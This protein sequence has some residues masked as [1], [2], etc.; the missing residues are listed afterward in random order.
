MRQFIVK[1]PEMGRPLNTVPAYCYKDKDRGRI[2]WRGQTRDLPGK[3]KSAESWAAYHELCSIVE[4]TGELPKK[5][6]DPKSESECRTMAHLGRLYLE[7]MREKFGEGS[8]EPVCRGYAIRACNKL[9][10]SLPIEQFLPPQLKAVRDS[11][12]KEGCVR[13]TVNKRARQLVKLIQWS[14]E[15]GYSHP[16]QWSRLKAVDPIGAGQFGAID[17]PKIGPV[18]D[19][20]FERTLKLVKPKAA[21]ALQVLAITGMRTGE[22]L[23]MRPCEVDKSGRHWLYLIEEHKTSKKTGAGI[24]VIPEPAVEI[25]CA[26]MPRDYTQRWFPH[27]A[28]WLRLAV[29]RAC[30]NAGIPRWHPHQLRHRF[31]TNAAKVLDKQE[32]QA[33]LRHHDPRMTD[34]YTAEI[35]EE[36]TGIADKLYPENTP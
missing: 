2:Y 1:F 11:L 31:A 23:K 34:L 20:Q 16:D 15:E 24:I 17:R 5:K 3:Y 9:Y 22:L 19:S 35:A 18:P 26:W 33:L 29:A 36:L 27:G 30:D 25:L 12:I 10:G 21:A 6:S 7:A 28:S 4:A 13:R 14:V 32:R 8:G